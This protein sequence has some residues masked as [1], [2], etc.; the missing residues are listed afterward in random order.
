[1]TGCVRYQEKDVSFVSGDVT[2]AG[3][4]LLPRTRGPH[5]AIV[6]VHG[7][8]PETREASAPFAGLFARRG[9]AA[10][11]YDKRGTGR[12]TGNWRTA[13][14]DDLAADAVAAVRWLRTRP[15]IGEEKIGLWGGSQGGWIAPL[16]AT[17]SSG[18]SFVIIKAGPAVS[19]AALATAKSVNRVRRAGHPEG[20]ARATETLMELQFRILRTGDGWEVLEAEVARRRGEPWYPLVAVMR[21]STWQSTWMDYGRDIDFDAEAVLERLEVPVLW[22]LGAQ[23]PEVDAVQTAAVLDRLRTHNNKDITVRVFPD[24]DHQ[25]ELPRRN[26]RKP[27]YAPGYLE[28]MVDWAS[29]R[30]GNG[31]SGMQ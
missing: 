4:L 27:R 8:G 16:A 11:I 21:H 5:P 28:T 10:L 18:V 6:F 22:L 3:S 30:A 12:S 14:F 25:I 17:R 20:A 24:A 26:P 31:G 7:D 9:I 2:L 15:E 19:P 13:R 1:M 23:D 29:K